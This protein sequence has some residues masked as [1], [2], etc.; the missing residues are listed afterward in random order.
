[1]ITV[2]LIK[3]LEY[4]QKY[5]KQVIN[6]TFNLKFSLNIVINNG[7]MNLY[8]KNN[9]IWGETVTNESM[10]GIESCDSISRILACIDSDNIGWQEYTFFEKT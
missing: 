2:G 4:I 8:Y 9:H 3:E 5:T 6:V 1:M 7:Y 10:F